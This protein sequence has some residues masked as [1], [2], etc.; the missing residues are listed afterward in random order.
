MEGIGF[1]YYVATLL[2]PAMNIECSVLVVKYLLG[3]LLAIVRNYPKTHF[4]GSKPI[5]ML[6]P[7]WFLF[8][9]NM[10]K[11]MLHNILY[12]FFYPTNIAAA[13]LK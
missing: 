2:H 13:D 4:S 7:N 8:H 11:N 10:V 6:E 12:Y 9:L 5:Y 3:D 1:S